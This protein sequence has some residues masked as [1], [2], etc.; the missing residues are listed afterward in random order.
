MRFSLFTLI[1]LLLFSLAARSQNYHAING[2]PFA[3]SL[4][5]SNN[6][7]SIVNTPH[8]WDITLFGFQGKSATN[9]LTVYNY[10]LLSSPS[11]SEYLFDE[12]DFGRKFKLNFN[13]NL[14]NT[15]IAL[16]RTR[17]I[18]FGMNIRGYAQAKSDPYRFID[19]LKEVRQFFDLGTYNRAMSFDAISSSWIELF[20]TYSATVIEREFSRLNFGVTLKV[21]RGI[22]GGYANIHNGYARRDILNGR[23]FYTM[24]TGSSIY[25]YSAN[26]DNWQKQKGGGQNM[27][28]FLFKT[29]GGASFDAGLEY[30]IKSQAAK[31]VW[32]DDYYYDYEWKIG[33]SLLDLGINKYVYSLNSRKV[34]GWEPDVTDTTL[35]D[36]FRNIGGIS[37]FND[38]LATVAANI[39]RMPGKFTIMNPMRLVINVDRPLQNNF[40]LNADLSLNMN[41][42]VGKRGNVDE[43]NLLTVTPRWETKNLG[44]FMPVAYNTEGKFWIG[45][46]FKAGPLLLGFHN[47]GYIFSKKQIQNGGGY[48]AL[49]IRA[50]KWTKPWY[51]RR[52][53]CP[54]L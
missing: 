53:N 39:G 7:S 6:P 33:I 31:N 28:D 51:D 22:S 42:M 8:A 26:Y 54:P 34:D 45:A 50:K 10:S 1:G 17:A 32:D 25:A 44:V 18:A 48:L 19:T 30:L 27:R 3:G 5:V 36:K 52:L 43:M 21:T 35:E 12:G 38:S 20:G 24:A 40:Y 2:S 15:R 16:S 4:G 46:A 37:D 49:V 13:V 9:I 11:K 29:E 41:F 14:F 23:P 47:L